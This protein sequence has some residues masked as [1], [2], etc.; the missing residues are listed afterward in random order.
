MEF[1]HA[2][3]SARFFIPFLNYTELSTA[4]NR[5]SGIKLNMGP[6]PYCHSGYPLIE[7]NYQVKKFTT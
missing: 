2:K 1:E 6:P 7:I 4:Q 3:K 5:I